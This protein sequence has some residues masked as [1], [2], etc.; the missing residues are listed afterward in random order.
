MRATLALFFK[1][2]EWR[3]GAPIAHWKAGLCILRL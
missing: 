1:K 2:A 3:G